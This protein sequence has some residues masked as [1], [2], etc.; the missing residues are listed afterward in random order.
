MEH[1]TREEVENRYRVAQ[2]P[3]ECTGP[4]TIRA[5]PRQC[6]RG[7]HSDTAASRRC[8]TESK[9]KSKV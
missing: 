1:L 8:Q 4:A 3:S 9:L 7:T 5:M 2:H 6:E